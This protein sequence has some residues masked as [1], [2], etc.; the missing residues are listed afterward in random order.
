[1][2]IKMGSLVKKLALTIK[3][4]EDKGHSRE[5][6]KKVAYIKAAEALQSVGISP[7]A[8]CVMVDKAI[9][10]LERE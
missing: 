1:M 9:L 8:S 4:I 3:E 5:Y 7:A 10:E 6:A 2:R